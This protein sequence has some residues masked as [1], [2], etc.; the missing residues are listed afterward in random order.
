MRPK[1]WWQ[2]W[3]WS[4]RLLAAVGII[5]GLGALAMVSAAPS[6]HPSLAWRHLGA[7]GVGLAA[8][9]AVSRTN[10][11]QWTAFGFPLYGLAL[12]LLGLVA[13]AGTA[14]LGA[15]RWLTV[16]GVSLQPSELAK[17]GL[18]LWLAHLLAARPQPLQGRV[19]AGSALWAA[20]PA[21]FIFLQPDL[22]SAS[23][24]AAIWLIMVWAA[25][26]AVRHLGLLLSAGLAVLPLGWHLLRGYQRD[27]LLAFVNP[28]ADPLGAGYT[29]S[30]SL[31]AIGSGGW[32]GR[33]WGHGTQHQLNFLPEHHSDFLFAVVAEEWGWLGAAIVIAAFGLLLREGFRIAREAPEPQG[34]LLAAGICGW[35]GYQALVNL[36]MVTGLLPVVGVPLPLMSFGGSSMVVLLTALGLLESVRR[37]G[38]A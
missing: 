38:R 10:Y 29:I 1:V 33:G 23:V 31:I 21:A 3:L 9:L 37:A 34:R 30:Q 20:V 11:R 4:P 18:V 12:A 26:L 19:V 2:D 13:V 22:G 36:G 24:L 28:H 7:L 32:F 5:A 15:T 14:R 25:G 16:F 6:V 27:R 8:G 35:I 17:L